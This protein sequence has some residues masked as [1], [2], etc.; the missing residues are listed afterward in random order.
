[1][2]CS[3]YIPPSKRRQAAEQTASIND[4]QHNDALEYT[5]PPATESTARSS[6]PRVQCPFYARRV[7]HFQNPEDADEIYRY[8]RSCVAWWVQFGGTEEGLVTAPQLWPHSR[9]HHRLAQTAAQQ[10]ILNTL[11]FKAPLVPNFNFLPYGAHYREEFLAPHEEQY[12]L[13]CVDNTAHWDDGVATRKTLQ[14]GYYFDY[15]TDTLMCR[16][17]PIPDWVWCCITKV[18]A[19]GLVASDQ[20]PNQV[21]VNRYE[22]GQGISLHSDRHCFGDFVYSLSLGDDATMALVNTMDTLAA[23]AGAPKG[24]AVL[25]HLKARSLLCMRS[26]SR[27]KWQHGLAATRTDLGPQ[28]EPVMRKTR[29]SITFRY[30]DPE[31]WSQREALLHSGAIDVQEERNRR[32]RFIRDK[33]KDKEE[34]GGE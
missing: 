3:I 9:N 33:A 30:V 18:M 6:P 2:T 4:P 19:T 20:V 10:Q 16:N 29:T 26:Q 31:L 21:I 8:Y 17:D 11:A 22:P 5:I 13:A 14:F 25:L 34:A 7:H 27:W 1:M 24:S 23:E 32:G 28:F 15:K 12:I